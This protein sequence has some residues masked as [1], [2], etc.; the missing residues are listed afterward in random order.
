MH[1]EFTITRTPADGAVTDLYRAHAAGLV[2]LAVVIL[3]DRAAA[4]DVVQD[5]FCG[6]YRRWEHLRD[7]AK[8]LTYVRSAV[9]NGCRGVRRYQ[10]LRIGRQAAEPV[11]DSAEAAVLLAERHQAVLA[12]MRLLAPGSVRPWRCATSRA[13]TTARSPRS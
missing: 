11:A 10:A 3:G 7:P 12:G 2:R 5:A 6:L 9:L 8:A 13:W 4:E 1:T